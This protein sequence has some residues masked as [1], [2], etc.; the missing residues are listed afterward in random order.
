MRYLFVFVVLLFSNAMGVFAG[1]IQLETYYVAPVGSYDRLR[2]LPSDDLSVSCSEEGRLFYDEDDHQI[3]E[4]KDT[5]AGWTQLGSAWR[6]TDNGSSGV[7]F[8]TDSDLLDLNVGIGCSAT[9]FR[10]TLD[11]G[12]ATPDGGILAIGTLG[13]GQD[14]VTSGAGTR[15]IWYPRKAAFRAGD[16]FAWNWDDGHVGNYSVGLGI[17]SIAEVGENGVAI[18]TQAY[19]GWNDAVAIGVIARTGNSII[20]IGEGA[21]T[22]GKASSASAD[23]SYAIG[24]G[25]AARRAHSFAGGYLSTTGALSPATEGEYAF[26]LG[27]RTNAFADSSVAIGDSLKAATYAETVLGGYNIISTGDASNWVGSEPL[28]VIG[29]GSVSS[30]HNAITILKD[31]RFGLDTTD[32]EFRLTLDK[33]EPTPD[34]GILAIG[35][36]GAGQDLVA[37]GAGTRLIWYPKKAAFRAGYVSGTQWDDDNIGDKSVAIGKNVTASGTVSFVVGEDN[38]SSGSST[39]SIGNANSVAASGAVAIGNNETVPALGS[40]AIGRSSVSSGRYSLS[41]GDSNAATGRYSLAFGLHSESRAYDSVVVGA[42]NVIAGRSNVWFPSDPLFVI[43]NGSAL[44]RHN[45]VTVLKNGNTGIGEDV[46]QSSLHV[47]GYIQIDTRIG[48]PPAVD[49]GAGFAGRMVFDRVG[50][51]LFIC[52][53]SSWISKQFVP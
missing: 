4:C 7:V 47:D 23:F 19:A 41:V 18:G 11:K 6:Q 45:A 1:M 36:F 35:S 34:G 37:S 38:S 2:L 15:L 28:F 49:C 30:R 8:L 29:N 24:G 14:L 51:K 39:V 40:F 42:Y 50:H 53:G 20:K 22:L 27:V 25:C 44:S 26:A 46:P 33:G 31:G 5:T 52:N 21:V 17:G 43:G 16:A 48:P 32:P 13:S 9:E 3:Y 12:A 10:L